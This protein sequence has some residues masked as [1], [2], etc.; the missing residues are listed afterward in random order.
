[1]SDKAALATLAFWLIAAPATLAFCLTVEE[2]S[3]TTES[4]YPIPSLSLRGHAALATAF[5]T[6]KAFDFTIFDVFSKACPTASSVL[7]GAIGFSYR[8]NG[9]PKIVAMCLFLYQVTAA[10]LYL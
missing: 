1:M 9:S 5:P 6:I 8:S 7:C 10:C 3:S 4:V 2:T